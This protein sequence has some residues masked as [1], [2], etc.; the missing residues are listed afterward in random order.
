MTQHVEEKHKDMK[1]HR[2]VVYEQR[3]MNRYRVADSVHSNIITLK[4]S[5]DAYLANRVEELRQELDVPHKQI[6]CY[7]ASE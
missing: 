7:E 3:K 5:I 4:P 1:Q 2:R 6:P